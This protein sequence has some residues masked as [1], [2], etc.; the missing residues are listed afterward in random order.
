MLRQNPVHG[1]GVAGRAGAKLDSLLNLATDDCFFTER[2]TFLFYTGWKNGG[3]GAA[4]SRWVSGMGG[5]LP[6]P[7]ADARY[8]SPAWLN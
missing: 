8:L 5:K 2:K 6:P 1:G 3:E 7:P 4:L